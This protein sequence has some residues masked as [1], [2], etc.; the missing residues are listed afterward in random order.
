MKRGK[1]AERDTALWLNDEQES[2]L[3]EHKRR[4]KRRKDHRRAEQERWQEDK[5]RAEQEGRQEEQRRAKEAATPVQAVARADVADGDYCQVCGEPISYRRRIDVGIHRRA[6]YC[7]PKCVGAAI[8]AI[9]ARVEKERKRR[10]EQQRAEQERRRREEQLKERKRREEQ[11]RE[12]DRF[13]YLTE[14]AMNPKIGSRFP[15][16]ELDE[17]DIQLAGKWYKRPLSSLDREFLIENHGEN[18]ELGRLLSARS[19]EKIAFDFYGVVA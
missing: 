4:I 1:K 2:L 14:K 10:E 7:S 6:R 16:P 18:P 9:K 13:S 15:P 12:W 3:E 8:A 5:R 11:Q 19:A 17:K